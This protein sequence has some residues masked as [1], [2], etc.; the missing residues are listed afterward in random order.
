M[1]FCEDCGA[2]LSSGVIFCENCGAKI[3]V[4]TASEVITGTKEIRETGIIYTNL[5]LLGK[6]SEKSKDFLNSVINSFI[7]S[8]EERGVG[9]E[10]CDVSDRFSTVGEVKKHL[11]ILKNLIEKNN[12]KYLFILGSNDV[13]PSITWENQA[14]DSGSDSDVTSDL[15]FATFD[16]ESPFEGQLYDFDDCLRVGRLPTVDF[17]NYFT[18]L[19]AVCGKVEQ[20]KTFGMSAEVWQEETKDIYKDFVAGPA[21]VTSPEATKEE[22][23][24]IIPADANLLLFNLHG[25][26]QT[27]YWYGQRGGSYPEAIAPES[28]QGIVNPYFLAV[29]ACYGAYYEG[30]TADTSVLLNALN[31]KCVTFLGSSRIAFGTQSPKGCCADVIC[32]EFLKGLKE[33]LSAGDALNKARTVLMEDDSASVVKTLAEFALYGDPS[34]RMKA[35]AAEKG[36]F[37]GKLFGGK[38]AGGAASKSFAKGIHIPL[39]DVR[40]AV[41]MELTTVDQK[42]ADTVESFVYARHEDLKGIKPKYYSHQN[43]NYL[44]AVFESR[45]DIG[46]KIVN[47]RFS[48]SGEINQ[49]IE[50]K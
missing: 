5:D 41:R 47:V 17:E 48:K 43:K 28:L 40:R 22:S 23:A 20:I 26:R 37:S 12:S 21:V 31:G 29:E 9:Y 2:P 1:A 3:S 32:G 49:M 36:L 45:C 25:S 10:L 6:K 46:P 13:I 33:G 30:R 34:A 35:P 44:T 8:A 16:V 11:D 18:N 24:S 42:I 39:P 7:L 50:S 4:T 15:P 38:N 14:S 27:Q 19:K